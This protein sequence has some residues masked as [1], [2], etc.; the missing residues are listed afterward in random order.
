MPVYF[1]AEINEVRDEEL[2]RK[3]VNRVSDI[4]KKYGGRYLVRGGSAIAISGDWKPERLIVIEFD[5][6]ER[7]RECFGSAEYLEIAALREKAA[8]GRAIA[9][10]GIETGD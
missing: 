7:L 5:S 2:Y 6:H 10:E 1:I 4:V 3:Y 8:T 9:V